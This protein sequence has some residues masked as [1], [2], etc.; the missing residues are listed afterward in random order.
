MP[1]LYKQQH[2]KVY[3]SLTGQ[4][5]VFTPINDGYV[6]M[7]VCGPTVYSNVHL[8]NVRTFMSFDTIFRYLKH[9]G[10]KVRYVRNITD[11]GHL[12]NDADEGEDRIAKK[13]RLEQIEPM[14]V[15]QRYTVDFHNIL[16]KFNFLPPSIEPTATGHIIEQIELIKTIIDNG[17]GYEINGSVYFDVL[18]FNET[19]NYGKLSKRNV[20]D[21]IHNTRVLDGQ[22]DKKNPQDFALWKKAEPQHIMRWPSPWSD[23]FPGWHLECTAMSTKYLGEHFDIHGGGMDLKF[24]HHECEIAQAEAC[25]HQSPVNY[26]MHA[27]M[28]IMNG[29]KM[30]K[31]TGNFILPE[32]IFTGENEHITQAFS[33]SVARFFMLQAHYRS[34]LDFTNN[35]LLASEKGFNRLMDAISDLDTLKASASSSINISEWKQKCYDAMNDDFNSPI[36]IANLFEAVKFIN[37]IK[38][39]KVTISEADLE[40]LKAT[41]H[42]FTFDV[43]G[44]VYGSQ[45]E[46]GEDKLTGAVDLLIKLR[47]EARANKDFALSDKIRDELAAVGIQL[48]DGKE[49]TTF[50]TN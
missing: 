20:E 42:T 44:L 33:A 18:K 9:L 39:G 35:G 19:N 8:G 24:P 23:G 3:N 31:S 30:A 45:T 46:T 38:D 16:H 10:Y 26:W 37:Q 17:F 43:L 36:L 2:I 48:N 4:K 32:Q 25:N 28:L 22:T 7:Y 15:V 6:G 1:Q 41:M 27:N 34:I 5:E 50:S 14:E 49:G 21:L 13:A 29:K 11:A 47:Q 12:E 40:E